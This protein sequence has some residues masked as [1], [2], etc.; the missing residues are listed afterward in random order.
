MVCMELT[1]TLPQ[2]VLDALVTEITSR[3]LSEISTTAAP[4]AYLTVEEA[5]AVLRCSA[6]RIYDLR[7]ANILTRHSDGRRALVCRAE[8]DRY[9]QAGATHSVIVGGRA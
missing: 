2:E 9:I 8:I 1:F 5:A 6:Q 3:V 4:D 7:S